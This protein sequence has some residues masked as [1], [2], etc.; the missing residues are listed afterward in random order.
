MDSIYG[1]NFALYPCLELPLI[2]SNRL[3]WTVRLGNGIA[4]VTKHYKRKHPDSLNTAISNSIND[5]VIA[6]SDLRYHIN[7]HWDVQAGVN[8]TH[9]SNASYRKPNLGINMWGI[10]MGLR[11]FPVT[12]KPN[13]AL[14]P[15]QPKNGRWLAQLRVGM[16][17]V[18]AQA[19]LG[20][21]YP[22]YIVSAFGSRRWVGKNK[23]FAGIDYSYH[24]DINAYLRD[25]KL[26]T[27]HEASRSYKSALF[28]GNEF[29]MGRV[30]IVLQAGAYIKQAYIRR[31]AIYQKAGLNYYLVQ[32][33]KGA[34]KECFLSVFL[35][36]HRTVAEFGELGV[37][38][39]F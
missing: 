18:S 3:D 11:Y 21:L 4:Y 34:V 14:F 19:P 2:K 10:H 39:G 15:W 36:T 6:R 29:L 33:E 26:E 35:K 28:V 30:G 13:R 25:N 22:V 27:G 38:I 12:S 8:V 37:G 5:F 16:S 1:K 17:M 20:P 32:K 7:E 23:F 24:G 31:D 9:I